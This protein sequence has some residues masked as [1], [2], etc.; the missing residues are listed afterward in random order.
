MKGIITFGTSLSERDFME[1]MLNMKHSGFQEYKTAM[2][3]WAFFHSWNIDKLFYYQE[4]LE[5]KRWILK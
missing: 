2:A 4:L 1:G 5:G 3:F